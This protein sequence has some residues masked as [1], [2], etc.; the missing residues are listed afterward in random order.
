[1]VLFVAGVE[2]AGSEIQRHIGPQPKEVM[3]TNI[4]DKN[5]RNLGLNRMKTKAAFIEANNLS[6]EVAE[7]VFRLVDP[8][9]HHEDGEPLYLESIVD[10]AIEKVR[11]YTPQQRSDAFGFDDD[12]PLTRLANRLVE[13]LD[14]WAKNKEQEKEAKEP[15]YLSPAEMA[16]RLH[17]NVQTVMEWCR[18]GEIQATKLG[19]KWLIPKEEVTNRLRRQGIVNGKKKKGGA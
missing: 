5:M 4:G 15:E 7:Q 17:K 2:K 10:R 16:K 6:P 14:Q 13:I 9:D 11:N 18:N 3:R 8:L 12:H 1:V 19:G